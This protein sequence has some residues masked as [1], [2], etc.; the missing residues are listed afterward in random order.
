MYLD[1][2]TQLH[3]RTFYSCGSGE[4]YSDINPRCREYMLCNIGSSAVQCREIWERRNPCRKVIPKRSKISWFGRVDVTDENTTFGVG[5][6]LRR[7]KPPVYTELAP[8]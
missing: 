3:S 1:D 4:A 2:C 7:K 6:R 5:M 8:C